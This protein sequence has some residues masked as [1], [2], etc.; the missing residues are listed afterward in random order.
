MYLYYVLVTLCQLYY[1][2]FPGIQE[3]G[4]VCTLHL[5]ILLIYIYPL[6]LEL[7]PSCVYR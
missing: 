6:M 3:R 7:L 5:H 2:E 4:S 1:D